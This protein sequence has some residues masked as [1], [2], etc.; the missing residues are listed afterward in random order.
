MASAAQP[1]DAATVERILR[2]MG[3]DDYEPGVLHQL[4]AFMHA[5]CADVF[6]NGATYA[7]HAGRERVECEDV[8]L[9]CRLKSAEAQITSA[10]FLEWLSRERNRQP[11][12]AAPTSTSGIQLPFQKHCLLTANYDLVARPTEEEPADGAYEDG[13]PAGASGAEPPVRPRG[14]GA[15]QIPIVLHPGGQPTQP[16]QPGAEAPAG[17]GAGAEADAGGAPAVAPTEEL[18]D[19]DAAMADA[20]NDDELWE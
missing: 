8:R 2:S 5:H 15:K 7:A 14:A 11:I 1:R 18:I 3:V 10:P 9:V 6:S 16:T 17:A 13:Q 4:L 12:P 19:P 20:L